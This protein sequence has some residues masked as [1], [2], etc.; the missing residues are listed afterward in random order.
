MFLSL[1][2]NDAS[3]ENWRIVNHL[4]PI[5]V[6][7]THKCYFDLQVTKS[8]FLFK[9]TVVNNTKSLSLQQNKQWHYMPKR[10]YIVKDQC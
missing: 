8:H 5:Q 7:I 6:V 1:K 10:D 3:I 9:V 2:Y 4:T